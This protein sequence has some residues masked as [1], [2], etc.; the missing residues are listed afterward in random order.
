MCQ[1]DESGCRLPTQPDGIAAIQTQ[2]KIMIVQI[3]VSKLLW[4]STAF[5]NNYADIMPLVESIRERGFIA[6]S[7]I[8][9]TQLG[10]RFLIVVG[11]NRARAAAMLG[12]SHIPARVHDLSDSQIA[13]MRY[14]TNEWIPPN[15]GGRNYHVYREG[16]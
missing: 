6:D 1:C 3:P 4:D 9:V 8:D 14:T 11:R 13:E 16:Y 7:A 15:V 2:E 12:L 10:D 5:D